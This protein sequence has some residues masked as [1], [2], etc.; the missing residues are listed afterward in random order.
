M[1]TE[2]VKP[3]M[4]VVPY[5]RRQQ[6]KAGTV[7][8]K[9]QRFYYGP[10]P[11]ELQGGSS[12]RMTKEGGGGAPTY[13]ASIKKLL[14]AAAP[15]DDK[16]IAAQVRALLE[17]GTLPTFSE[18]TKHILAELF[19]VVR[20]PEMSRA[21]FS[22]DAFAAAIHWVAEGN[23]TLEGAFVGPKAVYLGANEGGAMALRGT[24]EALPNADT[25]S[26]M[27]A[28]TERAKPVMAAWAAR[29][30]DASLTGEARGARLREIHQQILTNMMRFEAQLTQRPAAPVVAVAVPG[31]GDPGGPAPAY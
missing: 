30:I 6:D 31:P 23:G 15:T 9:P 20:G 8:S 25:R 17:Q 13:A 21:S 19:A 26:N 27:A 4:H 11:Y 24:V 16:G 3:R 10:L 7:S 14:R 2:K 1:H 5:T 22:A 29:F 28:Q 18:P 12:H